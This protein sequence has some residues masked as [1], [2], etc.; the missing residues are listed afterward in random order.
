MCV[1]R[2]HPSHRTL[3]RKCGI[4]PTEC[5]PYWKAVSGLCRPVLVSRSQW[6]HISRLLSHLSIN[7]QLNKCT[8]LSS[9]WVL[10]CTLVVHMPVGAHDSS[11]SGILTSCTCS[12]YQVYWLLWHLFN[13]A[14]SQQQRYNENGGLGT[15][16]C[17]IMFPL[18]VWLP[19]LILFSPLVLT[20]PEVTSCNRPT[21]LC[22]CAFVSLHSNTFCRGSCSRLACSTPL[23]PPCC[24]GYSRLVP[25]LYA[26]IRLTAFIS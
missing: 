9:C 2:F 25:L 3:Y 1:S 7:T 5:E 6:W 15:P 21:R 24:H 18:S 17:C 8:W 22:T 19:L 4:D 26:P 12:Q 11:S 10:L 23:S 14:D 16:Q 13:P 20:I